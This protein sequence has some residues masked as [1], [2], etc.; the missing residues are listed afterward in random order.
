MRHKEFNPNKVLESCINLFWKN[1]FKACSVKDIINETGVNR[2]SLYE[3]FENKDGILEACLVLYQ[4]RYV[5]KYAE[6][7]NS[8]LSL[9]EKLTNYYESF[10]LEEVNHPPGC[11]ITHI[12]TEL[13]DTEDYVKVFLKENLNQLNKNITKTLLQSHIKDNIEEKATLLQAWFCTTMCYCLIQTKQE[14]R[15]YLQTGFNLI[16]KD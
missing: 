16:L 14:R 1:G 3:E 13:A 2:F 15:D 12:S 8:E 4:N 5:N 6:V 10:L 11:F 9:I 7:L